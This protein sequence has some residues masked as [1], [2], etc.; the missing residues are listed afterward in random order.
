LWPELSGQFSEVRWP[1][2]GADT[3]SCEN[4]SPDSKNQCNEISTHALLLCVCPPEGGAVG[5]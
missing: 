3:H 5:P 4:K 1:P 2:V